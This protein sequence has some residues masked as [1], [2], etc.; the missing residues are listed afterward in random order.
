MLNASLRLACE[1]TEN[2]VQ[3]TLR[4]G[5]PV[6]VTESTSS[7][8]AAVRGAVAVLSDLGEPDAPFSCIAGETWD[9]QYVSVELLRRLHEQTE[10]IDPATSAVINETQETTT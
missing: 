8:G 3:A 1:D 6:L 10:S 4:A 2:G 5:V 9:F 7:K